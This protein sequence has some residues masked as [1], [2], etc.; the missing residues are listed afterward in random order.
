R[1]LPPLVLAF[2]QARLLATS[3]GLTRLSWV[4]TN[5][6]ALWVG[7]SSSS[8]A[9]P[10]AS[11]SASASRAAN[12]GRRRASVMGAGPRG[13][14]S[15]AGGGGCRAEGDVVVGGGDRQRG[16][17]FRVVMPPSGTLKR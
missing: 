16:P 8:A 17:S 5:F 7:V 13:G 15:A 11:S 12:A 2:H 6:L 14:G 4:A 10:G 1:S 9:R 3:R